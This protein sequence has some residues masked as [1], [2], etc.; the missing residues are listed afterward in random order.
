MAKKKKSS[1]KILYILGGVVVA[2]ILFAII[3]KS[4]GWVGQKRAIQVESA[5]AEKATIV[6]KVSASGAVQPVVEV[7]ISPE[8]PGEIIRM[9]IEEGDSVSKGDFL[10][11]IRPD[12]FESALQRVEANYNQ[13]RA[14]YEDAKA[15]EARAQ[16]TF[17]RSELDYERQKKLYE[18][19]VISDADFQQVEANYNIAKQDLKSAQQNVQAA[20][21][22]VESAK[23]SV[24]EARENLRLTEITAP[25]TGIVSKLDVEEGETVVGTSQMQGTEML[26]IADLSNMEVRVDV[27][28]NDIIRISNG[29]TAIIDVDSY[30]YMDKTF[31]GV[32][33]Q[34][35][36]T[37]NDKASSDAVTE[38]EVRIKILN[39][40]YQD[41][42][43][44][45]GLK[46]PFR[47]GMTASVDILTE[48]KSNILTVPLSA[49]TTRPKKDAKPQGGEQAGPAND[50]DSEQT[51]A[52]DELDEVVFKLV[53]GKAVK[54][55]VKTGIS[56]FERIEVTDG[57]AEGD[58]IISGPFLAVSKRLKD[59]DD[60]EVQGGEKKEEA[61]PAES[62]DED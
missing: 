25:M 45:K 54:T 46:Y 7:K 28:E 31:K 42:I 33:T 48:T 15:R 6:E 56:D 37:A 9:E 39:S 5:K 36:N 14:N 27:N 38:F 52:S 3:G 11:K 41:L 34:I 21:F 20:Q 29:D 50:D 10:L 53:D 44:E 43:K 55:I 57:V 47:P 17:K 59:G 23:A 8:V 13:Q 49:V 12:N 2:L 40:S 32:V 61:Q 16:A 30:S 4:Q 1:N 18:E 19:K 35:A 24:D 26:R 51:L 22:V 62:S 58:V 60:V